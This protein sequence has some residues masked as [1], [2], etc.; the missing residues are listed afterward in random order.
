MFTTISYCYP[1]I[2]AINQSTSRWPPKCCRVLQNRQLQV[3]LH[4]QSM[5]VMVGVYP[6]PQPTGSIWSIKNAVLNFSHTILNM[7]LIHRISEW[8]QDWCTYNCRCSFLCSIDMP[9]ICLAEYYW[10]SY[11][12]RQAR[13]PV[14]APPSACARCLPP[15]F[16]CVHVRQCYRRNKND[17]GGRASTTS[18]LNLSLSIGLVQ[19][20]AILRYTNVSR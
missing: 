15:S 5:H 2:R 1:L 18:I 7:P 6:C 12:W 17:T 3:L 19:G 16:D 9:V 11:S 14:E 10:R 13:N 4:H 20:W 8:P